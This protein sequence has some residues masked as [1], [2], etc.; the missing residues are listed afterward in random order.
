MVKI[1]KI[2][3]ILLIVSVLIIFSL[4]VL[5]KNYKCQISKPRPPLHLCARD[6]STSEN[7][8]WL[9]YL[10]DKRL[11][12]EVISKEEY[13][14]VADL[15]IYEVDPITLGGYLNGKSCGDYG[16]V[17]NDLPIEAKKF[18]KRHE[19]EHLLQTGKERKPEFSANLAAGKEYPLGLIQTIFF[20]IKNRAKYYDSPLCYTLSLWKTF[21]VYFLSF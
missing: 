6:I 21:K 11:G 5:S 14:Q 1:K 15:L 18:V 16:Y 13:K 2:I 10:R 8:M 3:F 4:E 17:R 7:K 20:S 19:L 9:K 12:G